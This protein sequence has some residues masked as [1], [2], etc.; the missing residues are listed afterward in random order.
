M[1]QFLFAAIGI[2][3]SM[4]IYAQKNISGK[5]IDA[6][7]NAPLIGA[8]ITSGE[9]ATRTDKNGAFSIP[10]EDNLRLAI[11]FVGYETQERVMKSCD[12]IVYISL[13]PAS[14]T[15]SNVEITAT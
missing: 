10:C 8:T 1:K 7:T 13:V 3:C 2:V 14:T 5:I 12:E 9:K 6:S 4:T 11:S 15:L